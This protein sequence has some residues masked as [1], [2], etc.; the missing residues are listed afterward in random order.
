MVKLPTCDHWSPQH[1]MGKQTKRMNFNTRFKFYKFYSIAHLN[2]C[3]TQ[4]VEFGC[5]QRRIGNKAGKFK[6]IPERREDE[7]TLYRENP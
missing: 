6:V 4:K 7:G 1:Q 3:K 5:L 2:S